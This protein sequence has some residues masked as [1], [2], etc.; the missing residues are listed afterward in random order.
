MQAGQKVGNGETPEKTGKK[1]DHVGGDNY[2]KFDKEYKAQIKELMANGQT[3]DEAKKNAPLMIEAQNMLRKWEENDAEV[4]ELWKTM[5]NWVYKG[6]DETY[7]KLG[8]D[9]DKIYYE[10][11]TYLD[12]KE[13]VMEGLEKGEFYKRED[14]SV[15]ADLTKDGLDE[16]LLLRSDGTS[17]YMTQEIGRA[18]V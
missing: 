11:T 10:S 1:G 18:H 17:V 13:K 14:G 7:K 6:F 16:K 3:E 4:V 12:G 2:V 5:N 15:W 9:F 8:V